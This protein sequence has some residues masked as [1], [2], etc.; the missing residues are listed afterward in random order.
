MAT[1]SDMTV[2]VEVIKL[3]SFSKAAHRLGVSPAAVSKRIAALEDRLGARLI[4]RTTRHLSLTDAGAA[5][6]EAAARI[7]SDI[8]E[9]EAMIS[10]SAVRPKG[11][12][13]ITAPSSFG[14]R[15]VAPLL[16]KFLADY[17]EIRIR[18]VLTDVMLDL[19]EQGID[20][21]I[22]IGKLADS[23]LHARKLANNLRLLV[24]SPD[25]VARSGAPKHPED[26]QKHNCIVFGGNV[27]WTFE[28]NGDAAP[29][30]VRVAGNLDCN[31]GE[32]QRNA[33]IA[34]VGIALKSSWDVSD[35]IKAGI[36][37]PILPDWRLSQDLGIHAVYPSKRHL[38]TKLRLFINYLVESIGEHPRWDRDLARFV[39]ALAPDLDA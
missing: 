37:V 5:Y 13:T 32:V 27:S 12:L 36:L 14:H 39:P 35:E 26:L 1:E 9:A 7:L 34:G 29:L 6:F 18:L 31:T 11:Q 25:Y 33:A 30:T 4:H 24:A 17:P 19:V 38:S 22:R 20:I 23:S 15:H 3:G 10:E 28:G 8:S 16:P 2:F 21:G